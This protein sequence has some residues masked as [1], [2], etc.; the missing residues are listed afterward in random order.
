[1]P[2]SRPR[3]RP[4]YV[5]RT[6]GAPHRPW[7]SVNVRRG[8]KLRFDIVVAWLGLEHGRP[9]SQW[10]GFSRLLEG[11]LQSVEHELPRAILDRLASADVDDA[12]ESLIA[13]A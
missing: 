8:D 4:R 12:A 1:M 3:P 6:D 11:Y 9:L 13:E 2:R 7:S 5:A 10:D